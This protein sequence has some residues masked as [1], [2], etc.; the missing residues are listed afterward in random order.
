MKTEE[1]LS[2]SKTDWTVEKRPLFGPNGEPTN[3]YGIFRN[4]TDSCLGLVGGKYTITQNHEVVEMLM[5]AAGTMNIPAV[6]GG[7][8]GKGERIYYQFQLPEVTIGGSK[9]MRYLTGLTAHDGLT[10]IG[11]GATN[12]VVICQN[13]FF[14]AFKDCEAVKHTPNHKEKLTGIINSLRSS[15]FAEEQM[16]ERMVKLSNTVVPSKIDDDFL[17]EIIGGHLESVRSTNRL[18][19]LKAAM[20]TEYGA[21][22]ETAYGLFNAVTRFTNHMTH[23]KDIDAK[24]KALMFGAGARI[25][26]RAFDV[27]ENKFVASKPVEIYI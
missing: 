3:G 27:I 6:R 23:Y 1:L 7:S 8:L 22:G 2:A 12:V 14:Q 21:H 26:Q 10:K 5:D 15:M 24:R 11:F 25:N 4:D 19:D 9:N 17:F 20:S 16:I 18:N 13:T